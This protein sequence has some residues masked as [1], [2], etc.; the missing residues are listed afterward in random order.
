MQED[1]GLGGY[2]FIFNALDL[3][4][5]INDDAGYHICLDRQQSLVANVS[6]EVDVPFEN[7]SFVQGPG[8]A[9][10]GRQVAHETYVSGTY[11]FDPVTVPSGATVY[12]GL[13]YTRSV[14]PTM[15]FVRGRDGRPLPRTHLVVGS[16]LLEYEDTGY[17]KSIMSSRYRQDDIEFVMDWFPMD[18]DPADPQ[19]NGLR[20]GILNI[21]WGERSDWSELTIT[22]DD[23]RPT[24]ILE[25][26]WTGQV[27]KG[28]RG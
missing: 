26:E 7:A 28:S 19:G 20:S 13:K 4:I 18:N 25:I 6:S 1:D 23:V 21:P 15:P 3:D 24:T 27:F 11:T 2:N 22:S 10:P 9:D 12:A 5:P 16:F 14:K 8:C 17:I